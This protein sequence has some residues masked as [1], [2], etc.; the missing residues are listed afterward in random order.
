MLTEIGLDQK[1]ALGSVR[2]SFG[3]NNT[4]DDVNI[5]VNALSEIV[6]PKY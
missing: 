4:E 2:I 3:R 6:K 1:T 5:F